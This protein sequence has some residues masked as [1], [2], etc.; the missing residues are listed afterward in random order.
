MRNKI[1][2]FFTLLFFLTSY[3][4]VVKGF[5]VS[6]YS[7]KK[8]S[9]DYLGIENGLA[10]NAVTAVYKDKRGLMWFGTYD[11]ISR[12]DGYNFL[13]YRNEPNDAN[14]LINN[15]IVSISG[16]QN[17]IWIGTK[18]GLS[19]YSYLTNRFSTRNY[20]NPVTA[21]SEL[22]ANAINEIKDYKNSMYIATAGSG[23]LY[24]PK[25]SNKIIEIPLYV[26]GKLQWDYHIQGI[27]FDQSGRLWGFVQGVGIV[28]MDAKMNK[29]SV[30]F[31]EV[32]SGTSV[33]Y[34]RFSN[35]WLAIE[36]GLLK[37]LT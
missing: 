6:N 13:N 32:L 10:N 29:L 25:Q 31:S 12:Y 2:L 4:Q 14:S 28:K 24:C 15:R 21:K 9:I 37:W 34:D 26:N 8:Y 11:G 17:E 5:S 33:F 3:S 23:L 16:T 30:V 20:V 19:I 36:G 27:D 35:F 18:T 22:I 7:Q 1:L